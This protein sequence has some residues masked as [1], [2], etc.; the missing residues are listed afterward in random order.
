MV[1]NLPTNAEDVGLFP[2]SGRSPREENGNPHQYSCLGNLMNRGVW[3]AI[4]H[5]GHKRVE[6][7]LVTRQKQYYT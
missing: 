3:Q 2:R 6:H 7:D 5:G 1:K 4:V